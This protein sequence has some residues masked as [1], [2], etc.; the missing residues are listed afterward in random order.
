MK[1]DWKEMLSSLYSIGVDSKNFLY[2]S[3][4]LDAAELNVPVLS[5]G[6]LSVGGT[7]KT[8]V[9]SCLL[10][11]AQERGLRV[12]LVA[13][14]YG[15]RSRGIHHVDIRREDGAAFYGDEAFW[16]ATQFPSVSVWTG[17]KKY[18]T[19]Q[20]ALRQA[21]ADLVIVDDG[22]QHRSLKR[23]FDLVLLDATAD[24]KEE[25]LLPQGLLREGF[26]S[27]ERA[28]LVALTKVN[29]ASEDRVAALRRRIP[30]NQPVCEIEFQSELS[31]P[32]SA[33]AK[34][35]AVSGIAKPQVFEGNLRAMIAAG[36][37]AFELVS[38]MKFA[39]HWDYQKSDIE[40]ILKKFR[41]TGANEILTT[42][43]DF[44]K[45]QL[46]P[47]IK[48]LLNPLQVSVRFRQPP[49]ELYEFLD[50]SSRQ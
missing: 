34:A 48:E 17:P 33:G 40:S 19:A 3:G 30:K 4:L 45:L 37:Q 10:G 15:A 36:Q 21:P 38:H 46:F 39:D 49:P 25:A 2:D 27:L 8:P 28:D 18:L 47:E 14:N 43:K 9:V 44:V 24:V 41:E 16:L 13:R 1:T 20:T 23:N 35:L 12:V 29:W 22:F 32:L 11:L 6:N 42:E 26:A 5:V 7:G 50:R 31:R